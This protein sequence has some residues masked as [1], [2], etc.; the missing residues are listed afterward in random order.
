MLNASNLLRLENVRLQRWQRRCQIQLWPPRQLGTS[1]WGTGFTILACH[2]IRNISHAPLSNKYPM[3]M[4]LTVGLMEKMQRD[5]R[6]VND[7][8][9]CLI[10]CQDPSQPC[11]ES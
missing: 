6:V 9:I 3:M 8:G 4:V 11:R 7:W 1:T 10:F 5:E 2:F